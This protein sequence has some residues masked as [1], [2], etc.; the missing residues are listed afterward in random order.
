[1]IASVNGSRL[2]EWA[3]IA[4]L[5]PG[6]LKGLNRATLAKASLP[7]YEGWFK[8]HAWVHAIW[9]PLGTWVW[10]FALVSSAFAKTIVWRGR[11]YALK[12][13]RKG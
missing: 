10:L 7:E 13:T 9:V 4:Q 11:R 2:A 8:R 12:R 1:V 5:S 3:L 6:M